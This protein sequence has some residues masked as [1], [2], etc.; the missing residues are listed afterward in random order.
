[1]V[2]SLLPVQGWL[3]SRI[4]PPEANPA[5]VVASGKRPKMGFQK[6]TLEGSATP[7]GGK[8]AMVG[9]L[10]GRRAVTILELAVV[11]A[12]IVILVSMLLPAY[13]TY[14]RRVEEAACFANLRNLYVAA[15]GYVLANK[16]WPQ[17]PAKLVIDEPKTY[18][19]S[20]VQVLSPYGAS[21][22]VWICPTLQRNLHLSLEQVETD[23]NYRIDFFA[24][25]FDDN[26]GT[27]LRKPKH[28]WFVEKAG[29][30]GRGNLIILADGTTTSLRDLVEQQTP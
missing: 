23:E 10:P 18:A 3:D 24:T 5:K 26:E 11:M 22:E 29:F 4:L 13:T 12:I 14:Q 1:M 16:S 21:H 30:H 27:P 9:F 28:P 2:G 25:P 6:D 19:K 15:S 20:W 17:I 7:N 8:Q